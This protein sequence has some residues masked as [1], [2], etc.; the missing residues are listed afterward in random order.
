MIV[1]RIISLVQRVYYLCRR[2][3]VVDKG[4]GNSHGFL[5]K[6]HS[7]TQKAPITDALA[8]SVRFFFPR[9]NIGIVVEHCNNM[10]QTCGGYIALLLRIIHMCQLTLTCT[11]LI[12]ALIATA[13]EQHQGRP[14][15]INPNLT[16]KFDQKRRRI[17]GRKF[18]SFFGG[19]CICV[20]LLK[21]VE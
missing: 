21:Y 13:A 12:S 20:S 15:N 11:R 17:Y 1:S 3:R 7:K 18:F 4:K 10:T 8:R 19:P 6:S 16:S 5:S 2:R 14:W 9:G